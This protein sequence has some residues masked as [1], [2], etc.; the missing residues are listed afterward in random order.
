M[1]WRFGTVISCHHFLLAILFTS[2]SRSQ[3]GFSIFIYLDKQFNSCYTVNQNFPFEYQFL[4][5]W[6]VA[7][8]INYE[9]PNER[10]SLK[11]RWNASCSA[12]NNSKTSF[13]IVQTPAACD[14]P[15]LTKGSS[16]KRHVLSKNP[17]WSEWWKIHFEFIRFHVSQR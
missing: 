15:L 16:G 7:L 13:S 5:K 11:I 4:F 17:Q 3:R 9:L 12:S 14:C 6:R 1:C 2:F 8:L 10:T